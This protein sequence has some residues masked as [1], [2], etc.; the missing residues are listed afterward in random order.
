MREFNEFEI[1]MLYSQ[2]SECGAVN[3]Y[4]DDNLYEKEDNLIQRL[5]DVDWKDTYRDEPFLYHSALLNMLI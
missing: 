5:R 1:K 2:S 3:F 4:L